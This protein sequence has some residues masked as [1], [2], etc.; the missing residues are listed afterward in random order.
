MKEKEKQSIPEER[1][2]PLGKFTKEAKFFMASVCA[3]LN[4]RKY[5]LSEIKNSET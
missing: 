4:S 3:L 5:L 1:E 2:T